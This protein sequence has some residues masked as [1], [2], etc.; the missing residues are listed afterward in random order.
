[1]LHEH[2]EHCCLSL[3]LK[4]HDQIKLPPVKHTLPDISTGDYKHYSVKTL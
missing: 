3:A 4:Y 2:C 1:M